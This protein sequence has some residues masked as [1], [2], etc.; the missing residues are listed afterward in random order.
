MMPGDLRF[1]PAVKTVVLFTLVYQSLFG[2]FLLA[3]RSDDA[4]PTGV[5]LAMG[6]A[7]I[8]GDNPALAKERA[9]SQALVKGV[10]AYIVRHLKGRDLINYFDRITHEVLPAAREAIE[11]FNILAEERLKDNYTVLVRI[12]VN[13]EIIRNKLRDAGIVLTPGAAVRILLLVSEITES[14]TAYWWRDPESYPALTATEVALYQAFQNKGF[15]PINRSLTPPLVKPDTSMT[16]PEPSTEDLLEWGTLFDADMVIYGQS[17]MVDPKKVTLSLN[18]LHAEQDSLICQE[19]GIER[20]D[21]ENGSPEARSKS[22]QRLAKRLTAELSPCIMRAVAEERGKV[23]QLV[24]TFEGVCTYKQFSKL[25]AF[26]K[27]E[28]AGVEHVTPSRIKA[29]A[30]SAVVQFQGDRA[31]FI[32]R[33]LNHQKLP[34]PLHAGQRKGEHIVLELEQDE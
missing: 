28:I 25:R 9:I 12:K 7:R 4:L 33:I 27:Q 17:Q 1:T 8:P 24:I 29:K 30:V 11:N 6:A 18:A 22:L 10:E 5:V 14:G 3:A 32:T 26:L 13:E 23:D 21:V 34:F 20:I 19:F 31:T 15:H 16:S 2:P